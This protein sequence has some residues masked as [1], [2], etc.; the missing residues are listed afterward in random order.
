[1]RKIETRQIV[2]LPL[3]MNRN[4]QGLLNLVPG[5]TRAFRPH[6]QFFN[7]QDSLSTQVNGQSRLA[8]NVQ[9]EGIDNNHRT[10]LLT[11]LIPPVEALQTIDVTTSNYEAELGRAGGAVTNVALKSGTNEFH[12]SAYW[13]NRLSALGA[14]NTFVA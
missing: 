5:T 4:F 2:E 12:G 14:R 1:G 13:Y 8:N 7:S 10:G 9:L 11:V 6:S 3:T